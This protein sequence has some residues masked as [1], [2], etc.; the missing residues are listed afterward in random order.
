MAPWEQAYLTIDFKSFQ[1]YSHYF[2]ANWSNNSPRFE[3]L[4]I[5]HIIEFLKYISLI[6]LEGED[7]LVELFILSLP[8]F[9]QD[10]FKGCCEDRG[11]S[12]FVD[13]ISR[14]IEFM[15]PQCQTYEDALQ[16]IE[17]TL[18]EE[19]FTTEIME[20]LRYVYHTQY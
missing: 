14:F 16:N 15:K 11:I 20:D 9:L 19:G 1:R 13:L 7:V 6:E 17:I 2:D 4:P 18:E 10:W 5:T 12:S 3:G 8:S